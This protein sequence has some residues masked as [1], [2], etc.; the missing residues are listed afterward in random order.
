MYRKYLYVLAT[1]E[2]PVAATVG[3]PEG[4][5]PAASGRLC[6]C[7]EVYLQSS[8][9]RVFK[10]TFHFSM[11][12]K[13]IVLVGQETERSLLLLTG[14]RRSSA[15]ARWPCMLPRLREW[16][17][18]KL[19]SVETGSF[20]LFLGGDIL[21]LFGPLRSPG[22]LW[23]VTWMPLAGEKGAQRVCVSHSDA[24][25]VVVPLDPHAGILCCVPLSKC[26]LM[27]TVSVSLWGGFSLH[28][29]RE[30]LQSGGQRDPVRPAPLL[31]CAAG[32][33]QSLQ[34]PAPHL[35]PQH[36]LQPEQCRVPHK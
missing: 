25:L 26:S 12:F 14:E 32:S 31:H 34:V 6:D 18:R 9:Q 28:R 15:P 24:S 20:S 2:Q 5:G 33:A 19:A 3:Q 27:A 36:A 29:R 1:R 23:G 4:P 10:M 16:P 22:P 21:V 13:Q 11:K 30:D 7:V 8:G 35:C 17:S